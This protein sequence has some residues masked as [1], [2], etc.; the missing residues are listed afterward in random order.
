MKR[1]V[2][3][4]LRV[5]SGVAVI[6]GFVLMLGVIGADDVAT[7]QGIYMDLGELIKKLSMC[8]IMIL[9]GAVGLNIL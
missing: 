9:G 3:S 7:A 8:M 2:I 6:T 1:K 5:A 4:G